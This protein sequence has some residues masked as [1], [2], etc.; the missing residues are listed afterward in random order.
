MRRALLAILGILVTAMVLLYALAPILASYDL[1]RITAHRRPIFARLSGEELD[2]GTILY[3][4]FGYDLEAKHRIIPAQPARYDTGVA[5]S[6]SVPFYKRFDC[7][8]TVE[9]AQ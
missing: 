3:R 1:R 9:S 6:F 5:L 2:G 8:T 4:G 7:E